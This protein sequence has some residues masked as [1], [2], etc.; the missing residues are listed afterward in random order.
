MRRFLVR[1]IFII[2]LC[3]AGLYGRAWFLSWQFHNLL[4]KQ[5]VIVVNESL[6][7]APNGSVTLRYKE[8]QASPMSLKGVEVTQSLWSWNT[9]QIAI[10]TLDAVVND[11]TITAQDVQ[12]TSHWQSEQLI[13]HYNFQTGAV[14]TKKDSVPLSSEGVLHLLPHTVVF[15]TVKIVSNDINLGAE[16]QI[17]WHTKDGLLTLNVNDYKRVLALFVNLNFIT[18]KQA[19]WGRLGNAFA[20]FLAKPSPETQTSITLTISQGTVKWGP[21]TL[22]KI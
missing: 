8:I 17:D 14:A 2:G 18:E 11:I 1:I 22:G 20:N 16:G 13:L 21:L 7:V 4:A 6:R 15:E 12:G 10:K 5:D 3:A 19:K 9:A